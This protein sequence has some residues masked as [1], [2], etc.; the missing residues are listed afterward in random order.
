[1]FHEFD[2]HFSDYQ[3]R[4]LLEAETPLSRPELVGLGFDEREALRREARRRQA[5]ELARWLGG[6]WRGLLGR[7]RS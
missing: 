4:L 6:F 5:D 2:R 3:E 7:R 1:M